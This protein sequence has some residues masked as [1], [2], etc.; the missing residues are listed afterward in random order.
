MQRL[1]GS[2]T[3]IM[4][5]MTDARAYRDDAFCCLKHVTKAARAR[6]FDLADEWMLS[7]EENMRSIYSLVGSIK[8]EGRRFIDA[9]PVYEIAL[10]VHS[11]LVDTRTVVK[12]A[13]RRVA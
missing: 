5:E 13:R 3:N 7:A 2:T 6:N 11:R 4:A 10:M 1:E 12:N 9:R 8:A